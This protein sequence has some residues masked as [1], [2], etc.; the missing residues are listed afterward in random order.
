MIIHQ[1]PDMPTDWSGWSTNV[2]S[3]A[4]GFQKRVV[5]LYA[6]FFSS[7]QCPFDYFTRISDGYNIDL[8]QHWDGQPKLHPKQPNE[9]ERKTEEADGRED[10]GLSRT[11]NLVIEVNNNGRHRWF[12]ALA[13]TPNASP[14][15]S[16]KGRPWLGMSSYLRPFAEYS[17]CLFRAKTKSER[18]RESLFPS[19]TSARNE[20]TSITLTSCHCAEQP[21]SIYEF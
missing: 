15:R 3:C 6:T 12:I 2:T 11:S 9:R 20:A 16:I 17:S 5:H 10:E 13:A 8:S 19:Y 1:S 21:V 18:S 4:Q 7:W 14:I